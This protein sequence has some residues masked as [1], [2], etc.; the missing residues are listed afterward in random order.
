MNKITSDIAEQFLDLNHAQQILDANSE[1]IFGVK[2][3]TK[4][5][6]IDRSSNINPNHYNLFYELEVDSST[7]NLRFSLSLIDDREPNF[8]TLKYLYENGFNGD[9]IAVA[10]PYC[11]LAEYNLMIYEN[12]GGEILTKHLNDL[13][14]QK[15]DMCSKSL[16][17]VHKIG[18][19]LKFNIWNPDWS[20]N[21]EA[22][23]EYY[24]GL[25]AKITQIRGKM[26]EIILKNRKKCLCHGDF[27]TDN[28][29]FN[30]SKLYLI[31]FG[32][33]S[34]SDKEMDLASF[35][36]NLKVDLEKKKIDGVFE[37]L[38][39]KF[40]SSY[41]NFEEEKYKAYLILYSLRLLDAYIKFPDY[42]K[43]RETIPFVY[44]ELIK[45]LSNLSISL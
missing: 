37:D 5:I 44:D 31:D 27:R 42:D 39:T 41:G 13:N 22:I 33:A 17:M 43:N 12:I 24:P 18:D 2:K 45:N 11:F 4:I 29:I 16:Q 7:L 19:E 25:S 1:K 3:K 36:I 20:Y 23:K 32:S 6:K 21:I 9:E 15:I 35:I 40:L 28:L 30:N 8:L 10:K 38:T 26:W 14:E 34:I